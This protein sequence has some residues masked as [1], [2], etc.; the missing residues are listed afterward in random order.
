MLGLVTLYNPVPEE[1]TANI[2]RYINDLDAL[3]IWD[4]SPLEARLRETVTASLGD[5]AGKVIWNGT[6][7]NRCIAPAINFAWHYAVNNHFDLLL[8]MDQDSQWEAFSSYRQDIEHILATG[9]ELV[10]TPYIIGCDTFEIKEEEHD[11]R[12]FINS[13]MVI[14]TEILSAIGGIDEKAFPLD[15][16]DHDIAFSIQ[17]NGYKAV[18]L[19]RHQLKHSLGYPQQRGPFRLFTPNYNSL[20][21]YSMARSHIICY[22]KHKSMMNREDKDYLYNEILRRKFIRIIL[23]EPDKWSRM[24]A[25]IKGIIS[26]CRYKIE[27]R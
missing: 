4:N 6:G 26:G 18:C 19:T 5:A 11:K 2:K 15:A 22:R 13:G 16:I 27:T 12:L 24:T 10:F 7:E 1:A 21:T 17:E 8:V 9:R 25:L 14:P 20:R 23:A 3:I